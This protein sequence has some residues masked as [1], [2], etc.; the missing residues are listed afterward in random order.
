MPRNVPTNVFKH[1][2]MHN[3]DKDV[4]W[5]WKGKLNVKDGRP[6][7]TID[8]RRRPAYT[9]VLELHSGQDQEDR[10][11]RH[12]CDNPVCCNPHH[13]SWGNHQ[14]NMDDMVERERHGMPKTV[15][16]AIKK[17]RTEGKTQQEIADLYGISREAVSAIDT[18]RRR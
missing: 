1:I 12:S 7:I 14:D 2:N 11:A 16:R 17:L 15:V 8:K 3:G 9:V 5:E 13:L 18:G 6:Y 4:C 10:I